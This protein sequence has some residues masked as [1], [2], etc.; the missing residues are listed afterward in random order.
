MS[1]LTANSLLLLA[2]LVWGLGFV[3]QETAMD[4]IGPFQFV[5][6]RFLLAALVVAPF[7]FSEMRKVRQTGEQPHLTGRDWLL[8]ILVGCV[9]FVGMALQQIGLLATTVTNAGMLTGLYVVLV[10]LIAWSILRQ[11]QPRLIAVCAFIAFIGTWLLGGGSLDGFNWGDLLVII[12]ALFWAAHVLLIGKTVSGLGRPVVIAATQ[13]AVCGTLGMIGFAICRL[14]G[15][16]FEPP[17]SSETLLAAGPELLYTAIFAGGLAFTLQAI[18]Q[19]Y[20]RP[21][22]AAILL[23]SEALF[24]AIGG[25]VLLA[26]RLQP[27]GYLGCA[28]LFG[29]IIT[30]SL[31]DALKQSPVS[32]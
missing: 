10:P 26:E 8:M 24:A 4:D 27:I 13:F 7:A 15:V 25:A 12:S 14:T 21:A 2:G 19:R 30:V 5:G 28:L 32:T 29:A 31:Q 6:L 16:P 23:S 3:A 9:F 20:T 1:R 11:P 18:G 22:D 17:L